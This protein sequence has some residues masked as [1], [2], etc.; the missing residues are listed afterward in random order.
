VGTEAAPA[1]KRSAPKGDW[2]VDL[3]GNFKQPSLAGNAQVIFSDVDDSKAS[4]SREITAMYQVTVKA[5]GSISARVR[6]SPDEGFRA[7][8][9]YHVQI[10]QLVGGK[11]EVRAEG[12]FQLK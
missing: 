5:A 7:G 12:S 6:L 4:K 11:E 8:R 2:V 3:Y 1:F 9:S 10:A